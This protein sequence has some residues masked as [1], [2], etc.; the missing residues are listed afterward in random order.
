MSTL[1]ESSLLQGRAHVA[2]RKLVVLTSWRKANS[3][4]AGNKYNPT[5]LQEINRTPQVSLP[6][7]IH[8]LS[9]PKLLR[10]HTITVYS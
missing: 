8:V 7:S 9:E 1:Q 4:V 2:I 6:C 5:P 10:H 3:A